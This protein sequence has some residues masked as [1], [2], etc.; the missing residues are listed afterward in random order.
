M[1]KSFLL[2]EV[3]AHP[4]TRRSGDV[5][6]TPLLRASDVAGTSQMKHPT[7]SQTNVAKTSQC[8]VFTTSYWYGLTTSQEDVMTTSHQYVSMTSQISL[9]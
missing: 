4:A 2:T 9:K 5:V 7:T 3:H 6:T 1:N 8:Y